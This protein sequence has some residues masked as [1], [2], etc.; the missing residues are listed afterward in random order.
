[1]AWNC[2]TVEAALTRTVAASPARDAL[3]H[4][5]KRLR[6]RALDRWSDRLASAFLAQGL[7]VGQE[8][9]T[10]MPNNLEWVA[11][12]FALGK[13]GVAVV[14]LNL[15]YKA[16]ELAYVL[17]QSEARMLIAATRHGDRDL[18]PTI[19]AACSDAG[20]PVVVTI[21]DAP[22]LG[23]QDELSWA[24]FEATGHLDTFDDVDRL[25]ARKFRVT[26]NDL[27][28]IQFTSGTTAAPKG[29]E[30]RHDQLLRSATGMSERL[31]MAAED[32][33][34][35][36]MPFFH[37]G[38]STASVLT[39]MVCGATLHFTD[40]FN[41]AEAL[42]IIAGERC[43]CVCG[44][45][46]MFVDMLAHEDF[47][48]TDL[49][50]IRA[51]WTNYNESVFA[52]LP[53][54]LNV[55]ALTECSSLVTI[56]RWTDPL[57]QRITS[58]Y[59][60]EGLEIRIVDPQTRQD[61]PAGVAGLILVRG[62]CVTTGYYKQPA[63][64]AEV[65]SPDGWLDTGDYGQLRPTGELLYL[66]RYKDVLRVGGEN[67]SS[68]EVET[69]INSHPAV[70]RS[71][72]VPVPHARLKQIPFA[73]VLLR[74]GASASGEDVTAYCSERLASFKVPRHVVFVTEFPMTESGKIQ[75]SSLVEQA[76][77]RVTLDDAGSVG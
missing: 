73:F 16:R 68:V 44:V 27:L 64:T 41:A 58:G 60:L 56:C 57:E 5:G 45:E 55:Y 38:G 21:G 20:T 36:P 3:C 40:Q 1:M 2:L 33:F 71:A 30:L 10:F 35:S 34:F 66:G 65:I 14:P 61:V 72:V 62:W 13:I 11:I 51:G 8:V 53:G 75:K 22:P 26:P 23:V 52:A 70:L 18:T 37:I 19:E 49:S 9:A 32:R 12:F 29:V 59:P 74:E 15:R 69:I 7:E 25:N 47:S 39:A 46:T 42:A 28:M 54:M 48:R 31:G 17:Q 24:A 6:W 63:L 50:C 76:E 4:K 43:T 77:H 67:V